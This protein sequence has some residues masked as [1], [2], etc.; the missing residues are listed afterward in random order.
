MERRRG[1]E[2]GCRHIYVVRGGSKLCLGVKV[3]LPQ[4]VRQSGWIFAVRDSL[5]RPVRQSGCDSD[6]WH[7]I[8]PALTCSVVQVIVNTFE[9]LRGHSYDRYGIGRSENSSYSRLH[10]QP[11][12]RRRCRCC[13]GGESR[14]VIYS[15][16]V[17]HVC[18][19]TSSFPVSHHTYR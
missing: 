1:G 5:P 11:R 19:F 6:T 7:N 15:G 17:R 9:G 18:K 16:I 10:M 13:G 4:L 8:G 14:G 12:R 3:S 2:M